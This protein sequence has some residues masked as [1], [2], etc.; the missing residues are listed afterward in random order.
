[1][2]SMLIYTRWGAA[3][4]G[5]AVA[6][7]AFAA[8]GLEGHFRTKYGGRVFEKT[9]ATPEGR[10]VVE[11]V[12]LDKKY[13]ADF[14]TGVRY[15][16]YHALALMGLGLLPVRNNRPWLKRAAAAF[17]A[18]TACFS[19]GLY[20][21]SLLALRWVGMFIV[22]LGGTLFLLGWICLVWAVERARQ[23]GPAA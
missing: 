1:M 8:H 10:Q 21:Y 12:P 6:L 20:L 7:G 13:L 19:G 14:E 22:P 18:G 16:M 9:V 15:Q 23:A 17:L 11:T 4:A 2:E 5:L 3:L